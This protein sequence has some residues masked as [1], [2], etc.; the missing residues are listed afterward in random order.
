MAQ[1][2]LISFEGITCSGKSTLVAK[3]IAYLKERNIKAEIKQDLKFYHGEELGKEIKS[4]LDKYREDEYY[5]FGMPQVETL[6]IL[7]KRAFESHTR[8]MPEINNGTLILADRDIDTVCALQLVSL[9]K[10]NSSLNID[11]TIE[12]I[13][14]INSLSC[15][16]P[17]LTFYLDVSVETSAKRSQ[18]RD[19]VNFK[20]S[21]YEFNKDA[22]KFYSKV[23]KLKLPGRELVI[24]N[25]DIFNE[26]EVFE[27]AR[28][29][30]EKW[31]NKCQ[32]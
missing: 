17:S 32:S 10:Q 24:I 7:T 15:V 11:K 19:E 30:F 9:K 1:G 3:F 21:D 8:L 13:R 5:R 27:K 14:G 31:L 12:L 25:T 22:K 18:H 6:L 4:L 28:I 16:H 23:F 29:K 26:D 20:K 2:N